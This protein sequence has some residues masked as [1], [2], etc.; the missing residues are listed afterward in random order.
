M[1]PQPCVFWLVSGV[2]ILITVIPSALLPLIG[3]D[4]TL[5]SGSGVMKIHP[6]SYLAFLL[7]G[8]LV[9]LRWTERDLAGAWR[10]FIPLP[11]LV[12]GLAILSILAFM[13]FFHGGGSVGF[14]IDTLLM[15]AVVI[16]LLQHLT[17]AQLARLFRI[18]VWIFTLNVGIALIEAVSGQ[19]LIP[20]TV[21]G[22]VVVH[23]RRPTALLGHPLSN[24]HLTAVMLFLLLGC[25]HRRATKV[26]GGGFLALGLIAFG[27]RSAMVL[28]ALCY[29]VYLCILFP[30]KA[31]AGTLRWAD[32]VLLS[33]GILLG[34]GVLLL[35]FALTPFGQLMLERMT[36]DDSAETRL[37]LFGIFRYLSPTDLLIGIPLERL[38]TYL[39]LLDIPWTIENAWVQLLVRFG[40]IFFA[41]FLWALSR[42]FRF[43]ARDLPLEG[44]FALVLFLLIASSN[45][46]LSGKGN[47][48]SVMTIL[49]MSGR[50]HY[51]LIR[52]P[53]PVSVTAGTPVLVRQWQN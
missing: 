21:Q 7:A 4:Y 17:L 52:T 39:L 19:R 25:L 6:S 28:F 2:L 49:A 46:S 33:G 18:M 29:C 10:R 38:N 1:I 35:V 44:V 48:L 31:R 26:L 13:T 15:P 47:I 14:M 11:V 34:P 50:A 8:T 24:A 45:N 12:Y 43:L 5:L 51:H 9:L 41:V 37:S 32:L 22:I 40:L 16:L 27:G 30:R 20:F 42:L 36:W 53:D 23:D 3:W